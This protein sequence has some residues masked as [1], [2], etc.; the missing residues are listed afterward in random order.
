MY[1]SGT[2]FRCPIC[3][4]E[5]QEEVLKNAPPEE[6]IHCPRSSCGVE[7][8]RD[9]A[10]RWHLRTFRLANHFSLCV[11]P[12]SFLEREAVDPCARLDGSGRWKPRLFSPADPADVDRTEYFLPYVRRFLFPSL[13]AQA[14]PAGGDPG[15]RPSTCRHY[16]FLLDHLGPTA[17][18]GV[19][20]VL[21]CRD[22]KRH[23]NFE[24]PLLLEKVELI[25]FHYRVGFLVLRFRSAGAGA[26]FFDQMNALAFL[27]P[28]APLFQGFEM[29]ELADSG[30][31][32]RML[33]LLSFLLAEFSGSGTPAARP[34]G[35]DTAAPLPVKPIY[36]DRMMVYTF[37]C[38]DK[39][40][41]L[42]DPER[43][44]KLLRRS[45]LVNF[46]DEF[47]TLPQRERPDDEATLWLRTRWYGFSKDGESLVV[48]DTDLYQEQFLGQYQ[49]TYY[50]DIFLLAALQRITLLTLFERLSDIQALTTESPQSRRH[51]RRVRRD[52][53]LFKNQC[54]FSQITNRERGLILWKKWQQVFENRTLLEEVNEQSEEID[55]YLKN[56]VQERLEWLVRLGGFLAAAVPAI[57]G[58]NILFGDAEWVSTL[59][60]SLL[61]ALI[62]GT[63]L[64]AWIMLFRRRD[65]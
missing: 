29:S 58:L 64:F 1:V 15:S 57:L 14:A 43:S 45:S 4:W 6:S 11:L 38:L 61:V 49:A 48:F 23:L 63:G 27:R 34:A 22:Q 32:Y 55:T 16:E 47:T 31:R 54:W 19:P 5:F 53:L 50:F 30:G 51:L 28:I 24:Y 9:D 20:L 10:G 59:R 18:G 56:R 7:F 17:A 41:V 37:S 46:D 39:D 21:H 8:V 44:R 33:Q 60:W 62:I 12:F 13:Y 65:D 42:A 2:T 3:T 26:T 52:L 40:T 36:D 25:L 35:Q